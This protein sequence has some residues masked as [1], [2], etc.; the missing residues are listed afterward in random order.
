MSLVDLFQDEEKKE[1]GTVEGVATAIV[2]NNKDPEKWGRVKLQYTWREDKQESD[3]AR[4]ASSGA[5]KDR[6]T[7][8]T[9][10]VGDEVLVAF[11]KGN[12]DHPFVLSALWNGKDTPPA[13]I[14]DG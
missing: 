13:K 2:T 14:E 6:G 7:L 4:V 10:E 8:W 11:D 5:G 3:W 9:P 1:N 12:V